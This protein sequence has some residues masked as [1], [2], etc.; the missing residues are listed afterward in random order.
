MTCRR[1]TTVATVVAITIMDAIAIATAMAV[2][3]NTC[4][5]K[6]GMVQTTAVQTVHRTLAANISRITDRTMVPDRIQIII[7]ALHPIAITTNISRR[8]A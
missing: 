7:T 5:V 2:H 8:M 1:V 6:I 4:N 3:R